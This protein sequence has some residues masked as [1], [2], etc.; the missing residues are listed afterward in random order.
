MTDRRWRRPLVPFG[1]LPF[2]LTTFATGLA[3]DNAMSSVAAWWAPLAPLVVIL[4][5]AVACGSGYLS[6]LWSRRREARRGVADIELFLG[7]RG[8][9]G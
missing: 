1:L 2:G 9:N 6:R 4:L 3:F 7:G 8:Q 5:V